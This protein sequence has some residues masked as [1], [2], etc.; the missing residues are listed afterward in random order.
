MASVGVLALQ[1]DFAAHA[2]ALAEAGVE[3]R[4]VRRTHE[5]TGLD[6][7]VLPGG[8]S[9]TLLNL[10]SDEPWFEALR[11][12][13]AAG[14]ALLGTCAGAILLARRVIPD[15]YNTW[16]LIAQDVD[17]WAARVRAA[18]TTEPVVLKPG[19]S[20]ALGGAA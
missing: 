7:L 8:E 18:T 6:G 4:E 16:P 10:M 19:E 2:G 3:A 1:G 15:H 11:G 9:T 20:C 14:G 17:A 13:H 5:L 12:F